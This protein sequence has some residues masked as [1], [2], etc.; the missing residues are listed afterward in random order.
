MKK[1]NLLCLAVICMGLLVSC[2]NA[3]RPE[4]KAY[5]V[6]NFDSEEDS[7][8]DASENAVRREPLPQ[9]YVDES[10]PQ[11]K[12]YVYEGVEYHLQYLMTKYGAPAVNHA[13]LLYVDEM[14]GGPDFGFHSETG[15]LVFYS[16]LHSDD[17]QP[18]GAIVLTAEERAARAYELA[19][20]YYPSI[21]KLTPQPEEN[22]EKDEGEMLYSWRFNRYISG[23]CTTEGIWLEMDAYGTLKGLFIYIPGA[24]D[25]VNIDA[26]TEIWDQAVADMLTEQYDS[27]A[28]KYSDLEY[29][30][31]SNYYMRFNFADELVLNRSVSIECIEKNTGKEY[32]QSLTIEIP[33]QG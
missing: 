28:G 27:E 5:I 22:R 15:E 11:E 10:V 6:S 8:I 18:E 32:H 4:Y 24:F 9:S 25:D 7:S 12:T 29:E 19:S 23:I 31:G 20:K 13:Y 1:K 33:L 2:T 16:S 14:K 3:H 30:F 21:E 26:E 17:E